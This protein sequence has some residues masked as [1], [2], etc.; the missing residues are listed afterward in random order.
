MVSGSEATAQSPKPKVVSDM[1]NW[2]GGG[3]RQDSLFFL[4]LS[5]SIASAFRVSQSLRRNLKGSLAPLAFYGVVR[6]VA[7]LD[8]LTLS[9]LQNAPESITPS[10]CNPLQ[11]YA[12]LSGVAE[13]PF[14]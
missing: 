6:L 10:P 4:L 7:Y 1:G 5:P 13:L 11:P 14:P 12:G 9:G 2:G 8:Q 3:G